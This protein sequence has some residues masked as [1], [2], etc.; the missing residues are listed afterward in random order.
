MLSPHTRTRTLTIHL[1]HPTGPDRV[2]IR[3]ARNVLIHD[4]LPSLTLILTDALAGAWALIGR[5]NAHDMTLL[6]DLS[7]D[8]NAPWTGR[9]I[10]TYNNS[11]NHRPGQ[12]PINPT[13]IHTRHSAAPHDMRDMVS[14]LR[15][16]HFKRAVDTGSLLWTR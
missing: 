1:I 9:L 3:T 7:D 6:L 2:A 8:L 5:E 13:N 10:A 15:Y 11:S 12:Y 4:C 16:L 14:L